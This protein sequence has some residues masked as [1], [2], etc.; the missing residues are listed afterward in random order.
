MFNK[1]IN[2]YKKA[3]DKKLNY[4]FNYNNISKN[5]LIEREER[6]LELYIHNMKNGIYT[7]N[8]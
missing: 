1:S 8:N 5:L 6:E 4:R 2:N 7:T 3:Y